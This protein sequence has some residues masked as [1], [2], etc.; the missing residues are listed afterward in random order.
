MRTLHDLFEIV[1]VLAARRSLDA[2]ARIL[3]A[4]YRELLAEILHSPSTERDQTYIEAIVDE[5]TRPAS[6]PP[7]LEN[8]KPS[9]SVDCS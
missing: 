9:V 1:R 3:P 5:L 7:Q 2:A 4:K 6:D 8:R